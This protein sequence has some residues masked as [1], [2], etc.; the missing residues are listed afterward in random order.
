MPGIEGPSGRPSPN[1]P[2]GDEGL[3]GLPGNTGAV[4]QRGVQM[5]KGERGVGP[6]GPPGLSCPPG[7]FC[8]IGEGGSPGKTETPRL[9]DRTVDKG[10]LG[11]AGPTGV[12]GLTGAPVSFINLTD[13]FNQLNCGE[14]CLKV[15]QNL[16][17][18]FLRMHII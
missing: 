18:N 14:E 13:L 16:K 8:Q 3:P 1:S 10:P 12:P 17:L 7:P 4:G 5:S 9:G 15:H 2:L 6:T 11:N